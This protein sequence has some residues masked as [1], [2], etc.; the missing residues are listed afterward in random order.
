MSGF[1]VYE[2]GIVYL[3]SFRLDSGGSLWTCQLSSWSAKWLEDLFGDD[4][5]E[6]WAR[7]VPPPMRCQ[8]R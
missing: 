5:S 8:R 6:D 3:I 1:I 2:K 4:L 7:R